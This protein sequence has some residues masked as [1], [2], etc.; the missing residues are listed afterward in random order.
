MSCYSL[1]N[2]LLLIS[3]GHMKPLIGFAALLLEA[4][5][6]ITFTI[7]TSSV[8]Y[9]KC[10]QEIARIGAPVEHFRY[11]I[12]DTHRNELNVFQGHRFC[13]RSAP[14]GSRAHNADG[15]LRAHLPGAVEIGAGGL[16]QLGQ[17]VGRT[18]RTDH[19]YL[20]RT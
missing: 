10:H 3:A 17:S 6:Q 15:G 5:P 8:L 9:H 18:A 12:H 11:A 4:R 16:S 14:L 2:K 7:L 13:G 19:G 20:G 1:L